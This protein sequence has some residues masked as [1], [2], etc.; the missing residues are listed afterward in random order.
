MMLLSE[1]CV[2]QLSPLHASYRNS[3][4][5]DEI[6]EWSVWI[7]QP[8]SSLAA[9]AD[10][11]YLLSGDLIGEPPS[12]LPA[13]R[14]YH[15]HHHRPAATDQPA[16]PRSVGGWLEVGWRLFGGKLEVGWR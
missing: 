5:A 10:V 4:C 7:R 16:R 1:E 8:G 9:A 15:C 6:F 3:Y 14:V 12:C 2:S 11:C 13:I